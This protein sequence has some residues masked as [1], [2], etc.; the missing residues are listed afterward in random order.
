MKATD[1]LVELLPSDVDE[2]R[3][4]GQ[5]LFED[6]YHEIA[7]D[8]DVMHLAP[9]WAKYYD[10]ENRGKLVSLAAWAGDKLVGYAASIFDNHLHYAGQSV[11]FNDLLFIHQ[12]HRGG[13]IATRMVWRLENIAREMGATKLT[14]HHKPDTPMGKLLRKLGYQTEDVIKSK[15]VEPM[16]E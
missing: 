8:Q 3:S 1:D 16:E 15:V 14:F 10:L 13:T 11:L 4:K 9:D 6:H 7:L 12:K 5:G 2:L